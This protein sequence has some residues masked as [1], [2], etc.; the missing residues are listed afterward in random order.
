MEKAEVKQIAD[1]LKDLE[2]KLVKWDSRGIRRPEHIGTIRKH[3][4]EH[5]GGL[6]ESSLWHSSRQDYTISRMQQIPVSPAMTM[7]SRFFGWTGIQR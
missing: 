6:S 1:Y 2:E 7:T 5:Y 4:Q 3:K